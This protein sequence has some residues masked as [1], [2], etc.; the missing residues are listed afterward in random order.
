MSSRIGDM[1]KTET[2]TVNTKTRP[3]KRM[4]QLRQTTTLKKRPHP[5]KP[6]V[7]WCS[8]Q[9]RNTGDRSTSSSVPRPA[10]HHTHHGYHVSDNRGPRDN[11]V[12]G[13]RHGHGGSLGG[14][15]PGPG[16]SHGTLGH[17]Q[18]RIHT[19]KLP[20][21]LRGASSDTK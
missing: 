1:A 19:G 6:V 7:A 17:S 11:C 16:S 5:K 21:T 9:M 10:C 12:H 20:A 15:S 3:K 2:K 4:S 18:S 8:T 13:N 14:P